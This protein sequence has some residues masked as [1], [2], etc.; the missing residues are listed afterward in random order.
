MMSYQYPWCSNNW[1]KPWQECFCEDEG[2]IDID[3]HGLNKEF[4]ILSVILRA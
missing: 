2:A 3:Y 1:I 4:I